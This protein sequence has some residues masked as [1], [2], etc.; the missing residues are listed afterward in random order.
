MTYSLSDKITSHFANE[1][2][3]GVR[4]KDCIIVIPNG[5]GELHRKITGAVT[6]DKLNELVKEVKERDNG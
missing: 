5:Y 3:D 1:G 4:L 6:I 2:I